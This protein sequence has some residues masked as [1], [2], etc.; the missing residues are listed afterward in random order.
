A[1]DDPGFL[2]ANIDGWMR[3]K[4]TVDEKDPLA[5]ALLAQ[6]QQVVMPTIA[7]SDE[8]VANLIAFLEAQTRRVAAA[9]RPA[10]RE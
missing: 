7:V 5:M 1:V 8:D 6:S 2:A 3:T 9:S 10:H 4:D